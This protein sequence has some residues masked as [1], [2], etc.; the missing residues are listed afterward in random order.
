MRTFKRL[1]ALMV[2]ATSIAAGMATEV[3]VTQFNYTGPFLIPNP[4]MID[5]VG[6][7]QKKFAIE[8]VLDAN[9]YARQVTTATRK[10]TSFPALYSRE[11]KL[12]QGYL[13]TEAPEAL[14]TLHRRQT[15]FGQSGN[16]I[17]TENARGG[18]Q[19][20]VATSG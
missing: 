17:G 13:Q 20:S 7:T 2:A 4:I 18:N 9:T 3:R 5:S 16:S 8:S 6:F 10:R 1:F 11:H 19:I 12:C 14:Q 15:C